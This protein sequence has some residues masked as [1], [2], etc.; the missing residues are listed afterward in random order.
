MIVISV[1]D[2]LIVKR[3]IHYFIARS[4]Q[5]LVLL[6]RFRKEAD[7]H[8]SRCHIYPTRLYRIQIVQ[9]LSDIGN[10]IWVLHLV[11]KHYHFMRYG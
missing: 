2:N 6:L 4:N 1:P 9:C 7:I 8:I 10:R 3:M 5:F 11:P